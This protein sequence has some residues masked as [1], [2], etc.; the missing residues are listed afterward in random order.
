M[1]KDQVIAFFYRD[2]VCALLSFSLISVPILF[3]FTAS[4]AMLIR[5]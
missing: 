1:R 2:E 4:L 5:C 3:S